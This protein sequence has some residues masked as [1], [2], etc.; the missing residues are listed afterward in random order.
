MAWRGGRNAK[1]LDTAVA[2]LTR[3]RVRSRDSK[4]KKSSPVSLAAGMPIACGALRGNECTSSSTAGVG[5]A[6]PRQGF[7]RVSPK[8]RGPA[9][10]PSKFATL[11]FP[12]PI[13]HSTRCAM[14]ISIVTARNPRVAGIVKAFGMPVQGVKAGK[15][16]GC[17]VSS[18]GLYLNPHL[19]PEVICKKSLSRS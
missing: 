2:E 10:T 13:S 17:Q 3:S 5:R 18:A 14:N 6:A 19:I 4:A 16:A 11:I 15:S 1:I 7:S 8:L 9:I 12:A